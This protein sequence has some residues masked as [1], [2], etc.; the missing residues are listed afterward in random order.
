[1]TPVGPPYSDTIPFARALV[2]VA[3]NRCVWGSDWPHVAHLGIMMNVSDL[4]DLLADWVPDAAARHAVLVDNPHR[5]YG[6]V[7][8]DQPGD[9]P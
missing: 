1:M 3:P 9:A 2:A 7:S 5:L 4:L 8:P 6:F